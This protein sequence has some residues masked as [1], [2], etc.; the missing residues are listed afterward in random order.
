M[1]DLNLTLRKAE[2]TVTLHERDCVEETQH[3]DIYDN[4]KFIKF[5]DSRYIT[6][7]YPCSCGL[8]IE[9]VKAMCSNQLNVFF[10]E[11]DQMYE[12]WNENIF[13]KYGHYR[14][15]SITHDDR[16]P[17]NYDCQNVEIYDKND[18]PIRMKD[19]LSQFNNDDIIVIYCGIS[20]KAREW[21]NQTF[22]EYAHT[23]FQKCDKLSNQLSN[24]SYYE[25][26]ELQRP[27]L[28]KP[29]RH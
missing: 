25:Y 9:S 27:T 3:Y 18:D 28:T 1:G 20:Q 11:R 29:A 10:N 19:L 5:V 24:Q 6:K 8:S 16:E 14:L 4:Q 7:V 17:T 23:L 13:I 22:S 2:A 21:F 15:W 26:Y 12:I